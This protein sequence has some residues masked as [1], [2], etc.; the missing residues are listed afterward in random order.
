[1]DRSPVIIRELLQYRGYEIQGEPEGDF[2]VRHETLDDILVKWHPNPKFGT[3]DV[4]YYQKQ[5]EENEMSRC[6]VIL[7]DSPPSSAALECIRNLKVQNIYIEYFLS[8]EL[9]FNITKNRFVPDHFI[10]S[11]EK[12]REL[13]KA[14][15]LKTSQ[16]PKMHGTDS[17]AR[18]IGAK[19]GQLVKIIRNSDTMKGEKALNY[20]IVV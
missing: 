3:S 1:M 13:M 10:Q 17:M 8:K 5:L 11:E 20:R 9:Q 4:Q 19:K 6:I 14:Y 18:F 15:G 12:K 7:K 2:E 16:F